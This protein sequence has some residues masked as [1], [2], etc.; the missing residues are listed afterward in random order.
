MQSIESTRYKVFPSASHA[1]PLEMVILS[2]NLFTWPSLSILYKEPFSGSIMSSR[3]SQPGLP[4]NVPKIQRYILYN[5]MLWSL[6]W[7]IQT[8]QP[9]CDQSS[10]TIC[11]AVIQEVFGSALFNTGNSPQDHRI[12]VISFPL[13]F[14]YVTFYSAEETMFFSLD[15]NHEGG[16]RFWKLG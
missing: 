4:P 10:F 5:I 1:N 7:R 15:W 8:C 11:F 14:N 16:I 2:S 13:Y 9:T 12:F 3:F 6:F